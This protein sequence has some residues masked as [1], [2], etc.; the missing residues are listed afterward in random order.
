VTYY[1]ESYRP[2]YPERGVRFRAHR[3]E[4]DRDA[5]S[6]CMTGVV[7]VECAPNKDQA[8]ALLI[9]RLCGHNVTAWPHMG[10]PKK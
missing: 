4:L 6:P 5:L 1:F 2:P 3:G 10:G 9:E 7:R 8:I